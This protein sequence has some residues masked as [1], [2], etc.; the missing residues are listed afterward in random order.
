MKIWIKYVVGILLGLSLA[1]FS[2]SQS[3]LS[4]EL[5]SFITTIGI[6]FGRYSLLPVLFFSFSIGVFELRE[7]RA[8]FKIGLISTLII[9]AS[10]ILL[11]LVG[12]ASVLIKNPTRIPIFVEGISEVE[13]LN[14]KQT[15]L[16]LFPSSAFEVLSNG[17]FI[18][19]LC[20][21]AGFIGAGFGVDKIVAKPAINLFDSLS[22]VFY[23]IMTF[24]VDTFFIILVALSIQWLFDFQNLLASKIFTNFISILLIVFI[25]IALVIYPLIL[26]L[27]CGKINPYRVIY[28]SLASVL[29]AF[30]SGDSLLTLPV[31]IRH[32]NESLGVRR[33][34]SS[35][36]MPIFS[37]FARGGTSL[38][39]TISFIVILK[40][41]SN[42]GVSIQDIFWIWAASIILSFF[43]GNF[44]YGGALI[45]LSTICALYGRGFE[46]GYII[47]KPA[48]FFIGSIA[49]AIDAL[50]AQVGTYIIAHKWKMVNHKDLRFYI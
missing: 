31:L 49:T 2:P 24:F 33:R 37:I 3:S 50:T 36:T 40:S 27:T 6:Q 4:S 9:V 13:T 10:T 14:I 46:T 11:G 1:F 16:Q 41:Y 48:A 26:R 20:I 5:S 29:I 22:R 42:L 7:N 25:L 43:I 23:S 47:L 19:P 39:T 35:V 17:N 28:A 30:F 21:L 32:A 45:C 18:L 12:L 38:V 44:P 34:I 8:L 15:F